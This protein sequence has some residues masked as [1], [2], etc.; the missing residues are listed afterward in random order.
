MSGAAASVFVA[1]FGL[2]CG[3]FLNAVIHRL[4]RGVGLSHPRRSFCP[5]C[6]RSLPWHENIPVLSWVLLRGKCRGCAAPI[7]ARYPLVESLTAALFL[8]LW[9]NFPPAIAAAYMLLAAL[10]VAGTF[11]DLEHM[12]LPDSL[13]VG[14]AA[15]GVIL[16]ALVPGLLPGDTWDAR[17]RS[18]LFG[19]GVGFAALYAVVEL[20]KIAFGRK[21]LDLQP[22]EKFL[23]A[24]RGGNPFLLIAGEEWELEEFF[25]RPTDELELHLE[26][27][28]VWRL[29][30]RGLARDGKTFS[31]SE[32]EGAEGVAR[33][34]VVPREA[35][36]FGDVKL[37]LTLGAFLG[38]PG[39]LF[40]IGAGSMIGAAFGLAMLALRRLGEAGRIPFGPYLAAG[41]L[42]WIFAGPAIVDF[43]LR[44]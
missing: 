9:W 17:L 33:V 32:S 42:L 14:G 26:G 3:S 36:G 34:I 43:Y 6:G 28:Q 37:M 13:T 31:Y 38:W 35:M 22:A 44:R 39:A 1:V 4:P 41:A 24:V 19:A 12:I 8:A 18:S 7:S 27:G 30:R 20:G 5:H 2:V 40:S 29:S 15:A 10:L 16:A 25:Y 21:R 11:I 23:L